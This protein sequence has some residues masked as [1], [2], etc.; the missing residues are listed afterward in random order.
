MARK[1]L[2]PLGEVVRKEFR[3]KGWLDDRYKNGLEAVRAKE[4]GRHKKKK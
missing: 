3:K 1:D 4:E 2:G